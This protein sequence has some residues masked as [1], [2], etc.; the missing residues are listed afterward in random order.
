MADDM[1]TQLFIRLS[2]EDK[3]HKFKQ[4]CLDL[5]IDMRD[6]VEKAVDEVIKNGK[7]SC[8]LK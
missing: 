6:V 3:K 2:T 7:D 5:K 8:F 4:K 1:G